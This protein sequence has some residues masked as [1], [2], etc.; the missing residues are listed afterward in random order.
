MSDMLHVNVDDT[1]E[2]HSHEGHISH[3]AVIKLAFMDVFANFCVTVGFSIIG[4]G[5]MYGNRKLSILQWIAIFGTSAGLAMSS[6]DSMKGSDDAKEVK[7]G[8]LMFG[9]LM[10]LSGTFF[11]SCV[12]V[13][14]DYILSK[15]IPPPL[16]ARGTNTFTVLLMYIIVS[17]SNAVHSWNY[18][19]L[20]DRT[21]SVATGILQG[22]RAVLIY[23]ISNSLYCQSDASQCF[24]V[25]KGLG[26][27]LV[28]G[29]VLLFTI[30]R[31]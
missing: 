17:V 31:R 27:T 20:I 21:G 5:V 9:T 7:N 25:Y 14:S 23:V 3:K 19:E 12:Y 18:Y 11:Y 24:T 1:E 4:S 16:P 8:L 15:Q 29:S 22:L 26:S 13:Y 10:T 30:S 6:L 2:E 28:I